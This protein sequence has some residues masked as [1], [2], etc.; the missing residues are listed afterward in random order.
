[1]TASTTPS[2]TKYSPCTLC[3][4]PK[5]FR[6]ESFL[7][8]HLRLL[9]NVELA[10]V[11]REGHLQIENEEPSKSV[12]EDSLEIPQVI[13]IQQNPLQV[14]MNDQILIGLVHEQKIQEIP[15]Y[16]QN[17]DTG[18]FFGAFFYNYNS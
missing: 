17:Y 4:V 10:N 16:V 18:N 14:V 8:K 1:M 7:Q 3:P 5:K 2:N 6:Y 9:H 12:Q 15:I 11:E 13:M